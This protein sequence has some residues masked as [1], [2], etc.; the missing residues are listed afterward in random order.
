MTYSL[1]D[2]LRKRLPASRPPIIHACRPT[3]TR[4]ASCSARCRTGDRLVVNEEALRR[5]VRERSSANLIHQETSV[6]I[7]L[8][9]MGSTPLDEVQLARRQRVQVSSS[10]DRFL[11]MH[12]PEDIWLQKLRWFGKGGETSDRQWARHPGHHTGARGAA[13]SGLSPTKRRSDRCE[14]P[15]AAGAR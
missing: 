3:R 15:P 5:A 6:K 12:P 9:V 1:H 8:F 2:K 11:Y 4:P 13:G 14:R 7:D 10:L